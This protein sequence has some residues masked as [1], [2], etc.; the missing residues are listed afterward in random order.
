MFYLESTPPAD[1]TPYVACYWV[2][3]GPYHPEP[4]LVLPD[5]CMELIIHYGDRFRLLQPDGSS[6]LQARSVLAGEVTRSLRIGPSGVIGMVGVRF[7]PGGAY[8]FFPVPMQEWTDVIRP[9][10][11]IAGRAAAEWEERVGAAGN[12]VERW[13]VVSTAL[14]SRLRCQRPRREAV[15]QAIRQIQLASGNLSVDL[16]ADHVGL[17]RR[18]LT[19]SFHHQVG[20]TPKLLARI[21]RFQRA[22]RTAQERPN[23]P[24]AAVALDCG[25][26]DQAHLHRDFRAFAGEAPATFMASDHE[27]AHLL[28]HGNP[29]SG[30]EPRTTV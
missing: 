21:L 25:Y 12:H 11:L 19:R 26:F 4:E 9:L 27:L 13:H 5:G 22:V 18:H 15:D 29:G 14:R 8:R 2:L 16:L 23:L 17:S 7:R 30:E 24:W 6:G 1:L 3:E 20:L 28:V 10:E